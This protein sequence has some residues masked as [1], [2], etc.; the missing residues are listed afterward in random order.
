MYTTQFS[1][2]LKR[3]LAICRYVK[4][5]PYDFNPKTRRLFKVHDPKLGKRHQMMC[6]ISLAYISTL[7]LG[8][9][10][11]NHTAAMKVIGVIFIMAY[12]LPLSGHWNFNLELTPI[13]V[14]NSFMDFEAKVLRGTAYKHT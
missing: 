9:I 14:L 13:Q 4:T 6:L 5:F 3:H 7:F 12:C 11:G 8:L 10:L 2:F 1:P